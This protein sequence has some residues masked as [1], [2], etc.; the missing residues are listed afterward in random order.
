MATHQQID[1][2]LDKMAAERRR[3]LAQASALSEAEAA[4]RPQGKIGEAEW[5]AKEQLAHLWEME[6]SYIAWVKAALR[7]NGVDLTGVRA[8]PTAIPIDRAR[9]YPVA[10]LI[11]ALTT[12]RAGTV[13]FIRSLTPEQF[14]RTAKS[15]MFG[16]LTVLQ[17]LRS[18]Y[19][20]DRMHTD[21]IAGREP[22]YQ[23]RY[24]GGAE[25]NRRPSDSRTE[26]SPS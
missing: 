25:P 8:E 19:R 15:P 3:F 10:D 20:H 18:F 1:E 4:R 13:A 7:E 17:W 22:E 14:D 24:R 16:E 6:R 2:L 9:S 5:S 21:Q 12:E 11:D 23:P 26:T